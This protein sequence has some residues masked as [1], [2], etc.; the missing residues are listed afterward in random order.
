LPVP[1]ARFFAKNLLVLFA[2][3]GQSRPAQALDFHQDRIIYSFRF[4]SM[5]VNHRYMNAPRGPTSKYENDGERL[6]L[7]RRPE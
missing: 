1:G 3:N 2:Q 5:A 7:R 6:A 4:L